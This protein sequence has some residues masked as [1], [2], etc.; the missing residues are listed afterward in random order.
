L[1]SRSKTNLG[2]VDSS[3]TRSGPTGFGNVHR[4]VV[5]NM[6]RLKVLC[7]LTAA[8][9]LGADIVSNNERRAVEKGDYVDRDRHTVVTRHWA[10][11]QTRNKCQESQ[12]GTVISDRH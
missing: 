5:P 12:Q 7:H 8:E 1:S 4:N 10:I 2:E 11:R 6:K 3:P 9:Y